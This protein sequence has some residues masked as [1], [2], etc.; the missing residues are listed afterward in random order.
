MSY[1]RLFGRDELATAQILTTDTGAPRGLSVTRWVQRTLVYV[2]AGRSLLG[3][4]LC[5]GGRILD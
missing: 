3:C 5:N 2:M 1:C 4:I